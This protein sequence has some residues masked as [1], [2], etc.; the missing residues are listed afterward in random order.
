M[1]INDSHICVW[2]AFA[3]H[4]SLLPY[5]TQSMFDTKTFGTNV[6]LGKRELVVKDA[7]GDGLLFDMVDPC[8]PAE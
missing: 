1:G 5:E 6:I 2:A 4:T 8:R 3:R 7:A